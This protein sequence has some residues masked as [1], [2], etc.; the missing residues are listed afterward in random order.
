MLDAGYCR[1]DPGGDHDQCLGVVRRSRRGRE[2]DAEKSPRWPA[3]PPKRT[4]KALG[5]PLR[6]FKNHCRESRTQGKLIAFYAAGLFEPI[7]AR[8]SNLPLASVSIR[9]GK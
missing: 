3:P 1:D 6:A 7:A 5:M 2:T 9:S 8:P 4:E